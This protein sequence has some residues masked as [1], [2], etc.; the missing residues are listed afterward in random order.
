MK[1]YIWESCCDCQ[2]AGL[3]DYCNHHQ[4]MDQLGII[5]AQLQELIDAN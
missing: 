3:W 2:E 1:D 4:L 5:S